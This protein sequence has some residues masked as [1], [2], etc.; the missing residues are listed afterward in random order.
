MDARRGGSV[1]GP[2]TATLRALVLAFAFALTPPPTFALTPGGGSSATDCLAEFGGTP[3]NR[4]A[5]RP[6]EIRCVDNDPACDDDPTLGI[7][8]FRAEVC[9]NVTDPELPGCAPQALESFFIENEQ[10]DTNPKHDFDFQALEDQLNFLVLPVEATDLNVCSG[11]VQMSLRTPV[12]P[13]RS[14]GR[15]RRGRKAIVSTL[16]GDPA[17]VTDEDKL[18][19]TCVPGKDTTP[20]DG[21]TSTFEQIQRQIFTPTCAIP[22]CHNVAQGEH[23]LSLAAGEAYAHLVG[24]APANFAAA[25][26]GLLRVDPGAPANSFL[27]KKLR[28]ELGDSEGA[29]MPK[30]LKRLHHV[31]L[32]LVEEWIAAGAPAAGFI[33]AL[34]CH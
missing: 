23:Q 1:R 29:P 3:A 13:S 33:P 18:R 21:V 15:W 16:T 19:M 5:S 24:V 9:V 31:H 7:C 34:G 20:C 26:A 32:D 17:S 22:T 2:G 12:Q 25:S 6:R 8:Q 10:P 30:D 14:G 4:P 28:G 11:A 27:L